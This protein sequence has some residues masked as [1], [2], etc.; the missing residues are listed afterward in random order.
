MA[1]L[2]IAQAQRNSG[3]HAQ[4]TPAP[5]PPDASRPTRGMHGVALVMAAALSLGL[6][7]CGGGDDAGA[8]TP[9]TNN[10]T[11]APTPSPT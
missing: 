9:P 3:A 5:I 10:N 1:E 2:L 8:A 7:A 4:P 6:T 11:P